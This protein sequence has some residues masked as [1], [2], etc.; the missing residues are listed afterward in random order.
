M[1]IDC[2]YSDRLIWKNKDTGPYINGNLLNDNTITVDQ[3][4]KYQL[5]IWTIDF[6]LEK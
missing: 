5:F 3:W 1:I 4:G 6:T 2:G